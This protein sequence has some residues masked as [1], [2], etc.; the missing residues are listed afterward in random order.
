MST[1]DTTIEPVVEAVLKLFNLMMEE[2]VT[3]LPDPLSP[4]M[5]KVS[6]L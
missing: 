2:A 1:P 3:D 4:T 5:P 6:P